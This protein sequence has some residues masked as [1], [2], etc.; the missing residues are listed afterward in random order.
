[1]C[2]LH[3]STDTDGE[4]EAIEAKALSLA[5][6]YNFVTE[7]TSL[8]VVQENSDGNF[9]LNG[10][11]QVNGNLEEFDLAPGGGVFNSGRG[12]TVA[13]KIISPIPNN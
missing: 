9:T 7:L 5:L 2:L 3:Y 11:G 12:G 4:K 6:K 10:D 1:M 8:I 13:I